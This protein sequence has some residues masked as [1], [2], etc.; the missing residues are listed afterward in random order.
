[1]E[2]VADRKKRV[3][4]I[5]T[6]LK[7]QYPD[8]KCLLDHSTPIELLVATILAAQ[9]T[10]ER[11][12]KETPK[13]FARY[14]TAA[15]YAAAPQPELEK[16][17]RSCGTFRRKA[18]AIK[19]A[20]QAIADEHGGEVPADLDV[21]SALPGVGRKTANVVL[22]NCFGLPSIIVD[23][24]ALRL[25]GRLGLATPHNVEKK[26][27]DKIERELMEVV[28]KRD[29]TLFSHLL[30]FHGRF[31]CLARK[32]KCPECVIDSL[33]PYP[34]KTPREGAETKELF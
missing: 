11:V 9:C 22:A 16:M 32:P 25:S 5:I 8:A 28:P 10:D 20:C 33:C 29:W 7:K 6:R 30:T 27:A 14:K 4:K 34:D 17:I 12:N 13:V 1:M 26:Y 24:H 31:T 3:R 18:K 19:E 21:L 2:P 23:T 15:D